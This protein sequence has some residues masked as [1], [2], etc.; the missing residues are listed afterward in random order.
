MRWMSLLWAG[1]TAFILLLAISLWF[2]RRRAEVPVLKITP[3]TSS[4]AE[5]DQLVEVSDDLFCI[6]DATGKL[7]RANRAFR[8]RLTGH[9]SM[10][11]DLAPLLDR[12]DAESDGAVRLSLRTRRPAG[13]VTGPCALG[14][15]LKVLTIPTQDGRFG[16]L[17]RDLSESAGRE[18]HIR[19][20]GQF[21][22]ALP[23]A[24]IAV[25]PVTNRLTFGNTVFRESFGY[26]DVEAA[27]VDLETL[28]MQQGVAGQRLRD[29]A[30]ARQS[31]PVLTS[32]RRVDG[33]SFAARVQ[34]TL[35]RRQSGAPDSLVLTI[36]DVTIE[37]EATRQRDLMAA[38]VEGTTD[39]V[40]ITD[41]LG[42]VTYANAAAAQLYTGQGA[43]VIGATLRPR[44]A[45]AAELSTGA[46]QMLLEAQAAAYRLP[47]ALEEP[48]R[49]TSVALSLVRPANT[50]SPVG[51]VAIVH[52]LTAERELQERVLRSQKLATLGELS[53]TI[54][55][56]IRNPLTCL[57]SDSE[58][59]IEMLAQIGGADEARE[60]A[61]DIREAA[62]RIMTI[63]TEVR[64][65]SYM[66][67][68]SDAAARFG[69][70]V[71]S[72]LALAGPRVRAHCDI[73]MSDTAAPP[74]AVDVGHLSQALLNVVVNAAQ[75]L[76][77]S[78]R[79][80]TLSFVEGSDGSRAWLRVTDDG[81]GISPEIQARL[82]REY[83]TT[84]ER[85]QGTGF[86]VRV[87]AELLQRAGGSLSVE[88][89]LGKG[90][91]FTISLPLARAAAPLPR[92][93][94]RHGSITPM[95]PDLV[96]IALST[97]DLTRTLQ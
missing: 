33:S 56:E 17:I 86:G 35:I 26:P 74:V 21:L 1:L 19:R 43:G 82:F 81:P 28:A 97:G 29:S 91:T 22:E 69:E 7:V 92:P 53:A 14:A 45:T 73:V 96:E 54:N 41:L 90:T 4:R 36:E 94:L 57:M 75:A 83:V 20:L 59:L 44:K 8:D 87:S 34:G 68:S 88:S 76:E 12:N 40:L 64:G 5:W 24:V 84:K 67:Q 66:G 93:S 25:D 37:R 30:F 31:A 85:G 15:K 71:R 79:R 62:K 65:F 72:V 18:D 52:D 55:H 6:I 27:Q 70:V 51:Y 11:E 46:S 38:A 48:S 32:L 78:G 2:L 16:V 50:A 60:L 13:G 39:G 77:E 95:L 80:G 61:R 89:E 9:G 23:L 42:T 63:A 58:A 3:A 47:P 10:G 49:P